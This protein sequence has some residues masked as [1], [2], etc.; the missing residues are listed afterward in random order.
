MAGPLKGSVMGAVRRATRFFAMA[1]VLSARDFW[2]G[3]WA[4]SSASKVSTRKRSMPSA[5]R[6]RAT[7]T[8]RATWLGVATRAPCGG[9]EVVG[10]GGGG[11]AD[12]VEED[13]GELLE[14]AGELAEAVLPGG[15]V[16]DERRARGA[17]WRWAVGLVG[18]GAEV[19]GGVL[20]LGA[21]LLVGLDLE[22]AVD[23][24]A[25]AAVGGVPEAAGDG[26]AVV[27][28]GEGMVV[29]AELRW[30]PWVLSSA[31]VPMR[32]WM[33]AMRRRA[34]GGAGDGAVLGATMLM[35]SASE[36]A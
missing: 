2:S 22:V 11:H 19:G 21:D 9:D 3:R 5:A 33:S 1:R 34:A 36:T 15:P 13:V 17:G 4:A 30:S 25:V 16:D 35:A 18:L 8:R 7:M 14:E 29:R 27:G 20:F 23:G 24:S 6:V 10:L 12:G 26:G 28:E 31:G 32:T